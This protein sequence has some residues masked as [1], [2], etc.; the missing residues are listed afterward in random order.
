MESFPHSQV[1]P[2]MSKTMATYI[3]PRILFTYGS[4]E[5]SHARE[6]VNLTLTGMVK[7]VHTSRTSVVSAW[8]PQVWPRVFIHP[9]PHCPHMWNKRDSRHAQ[10]LIAIDKVVL[11]KVI[12]ICPTYNPYIHY[13]VATG[14]MCYH[15][16]NSIWVLPTNRML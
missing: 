4:Y 13:I 15:W 2:R 1:W 11:T 14:H 3:L 16:V 10:A 5:F 7:Y 6:Y 9:C 12:Q 8:I